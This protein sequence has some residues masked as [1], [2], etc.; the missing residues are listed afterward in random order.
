MEAVDTNHLY[1]ILAGPG[2]FEKSDGS[3]LNVV[4]M[5]AEGFNETKALR[6]LVHERFNQNEKAI[7]ALQSVTSGRF[8]NLENQL[9]QHMRQGKTASL[10]AIQSQLESLQ[11]LVSK[12]K[13][14]HGMQISKVNTQLTSHLAGKTKLQETLTD[15]NIRFEILDKANDEFN[16][17]LGELKRSMKPGNIA[18]SS[19]LIEC[20]LE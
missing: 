2:H 8:S 15:L 18:P 9:D 16:S 4:Q 19:E 10:P 3:M 6:T 13:T 5:I 17:E 1:N 14:D 11:D 7:V 12:V 20:R